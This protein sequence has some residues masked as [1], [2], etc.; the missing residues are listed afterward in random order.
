MMQLKVA[1]IAGAGLLA[2]AGA[3]ALLATE[4]ITYTYDAKG[5]VAKVVHSGTVNNGVTTEYTHDKT[6]NR[7]RV[8][9]TGA[10]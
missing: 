9:V 8:K 7:T 6:D 4:A 3:T 10:P 2:I 5:R 1:V